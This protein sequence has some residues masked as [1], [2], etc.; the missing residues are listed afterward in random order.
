MTDFEDLRAVVALEQHE[1][2]G[3]AAVALAV[4]QPA[5]TKRI[6]RLEERMG[7]ALFL[8]HARGV[9]PTPAAQHLARQGRQLLREAEHLEASTRQSLSG[10]VGELRIGAGLTTLLSGLPGMIGAFRQQYPGVRVTVRDMSTG[11]QLA[12]LANNELDIGFV[13]QVVAPAGLV[14]EPWFEDR[15]EMAVPVAMAKAGRKEVFASPFIL[16][17]RHVSPT[18]HDHVVA[19]CHASGFT[20]NV[21]QEAHQILTLLALVESGLG[22]SLVPQSC[23]RLGLA[24]VVMRNLPLEA[25]NWTVALATNKRSQ[26]VVER[27]LPFAR[28]LKKSN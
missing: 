7:G 1:H 16:V 17:S 5:L 18:F 21:V 3:R 4:S 26:S 23:R 28:T 10:E 15:L 11:A 8:R 19:T 27:F 9:T 25:A 6:Q 12:A 20:P 13:R 22:V 24:G 2:F 14:L